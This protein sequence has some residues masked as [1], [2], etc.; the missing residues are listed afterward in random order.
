MDVGRFWA[1]RAVRFSPHVKS[2]LR[3]ARA[4]FTRGVFYWRPG[5][6]CSNVSKV[7]LCVSAKKTVVERGGTRAL[8]ILWDGKK[9]KRKA[10]KPRA[11]K[12]GCRKFA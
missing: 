6:V 5:N 8:G 1:A 12:G 4:V 10:D 11:P 9:E 2:I 3:F 7:S